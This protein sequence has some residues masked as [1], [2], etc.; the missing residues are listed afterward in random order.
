[1]LSHKILSGRSV[2]ITS[3]P[4]HIRVKEY[5]NWFSGV[6]AGH[7]LQLFDNGPG[8][9]TDRVAEFTKLLSSEK[10]NF[11]IGLGA[12]ERKSKT[13]HGEWFS[14]LAQFSNQPGFRGVWIFP[15]G[16]PYQPVLGKI[17]AHLNQEALE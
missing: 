9:G 16:M 11:R 6:V 1:M 12:F 15:A 13:R 2:W 17:T 7:I 4:E 3:L 14:Q 8:F 10:I 5:D